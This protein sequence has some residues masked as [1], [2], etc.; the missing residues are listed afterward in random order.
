MRHIFH[1]RRIKC[2]VKNVPYICQLNRVIVYCSKRR[3]GI[4]V[5][6]NRK[7]DYI[8][9]IA[10]V[11]SISVAA[12]NLGISQP[13]LSAHLKKKERELGTMLFDRSRQPL[14]LTE[15]GKAY[16][17]YIDKATA[18]EKELQQSITDIE[19]LNM[20]RVTVGSA[21]FFN[22]AYLPKV[23]AAFYERFPDIELEIVDGKIPEI[24]TSAWNG[25]VDLFITSDNDEPERFHYDKL[26]D[27][28]IYLAVPRQWDINKTL[29][30]KAIQ[31][32]IE[33][34]PLSKEEFQNLCKRPFVIL[35]KNQDIGKKVRKLFRHFDCR[36]DHVIEAEQTLTTLALTVSGVGSSLIA[37]SSIE[38]DL[39]NEKTVLYLAD[40][41]IC[42]R[43]IYIAYPKNKYLSKAVSEFIDVLKEINR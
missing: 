22:M 41:Q 4:I 12:E 39:M 38:N 20:G 11:H 42:K 3:E 24:K 6:R 43:K 28:I 17:K 13:A 14:Q 19:G 8:K 7:A 33:P 26:I 37:R 16:L 2:Y 21:S 25:R 1:D 36:P 18:L 27:E 15:T 31:K 35:N 30:E 9:A 10:E 29:K 5:K 40:P 23:I 32:G 34:E